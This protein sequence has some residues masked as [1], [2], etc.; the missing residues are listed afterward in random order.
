MYENTELMLDVG[1]A[2][3]IKLAARRAGATNADLKKLCEGDMFTRIIPVLRGLA[4][5]VQVRHIIDC[6]AKPFIPDELEVEE[7]HKGGQMEWSV[8]KTL[9]YLSELQKKGKC[10]RG[11]KLHEELRNMHPY[12]ANTLDYLLA[13]VELIPEEWKGKIIFFWGT[14]YRGPVGHLYVRYLYWEGGQWRGHYRWL[15]HDFHSSSP[16]VL[17]A[18]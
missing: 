11:Y 6:D 14:I 18:S 1:Q 9:L 13:H 4:D 5:V 8:G 2:N 17:C 15:S 16:A 7:H 10:I 3:E 12:N